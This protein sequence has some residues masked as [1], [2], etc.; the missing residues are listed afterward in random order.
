V[1]VEGERGCFGC[2]EAEEG[3]S[4]ALDGWDDLIG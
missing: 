4:G 3:V 2:S 1:E